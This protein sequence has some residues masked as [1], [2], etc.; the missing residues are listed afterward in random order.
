M[1]LRLRIGQNS[2][3]SVVFIPHLSHPPSPM[4]YDWSGGRCEYTQPGGSNQ[5]SIRSTVYFFSSKNYNKQSVVIRYYDDWFDDHQKEEE[6]VFAADHSV[7]IQQQLFRRTN[8]SHTARLMDQDDD[9]RSEGSGVP[10]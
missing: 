6:I 10:P 8:K 9:P 4:L 5:N 2:W 1:L 7:D 3:M